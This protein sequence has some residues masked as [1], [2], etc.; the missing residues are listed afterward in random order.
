M[1]TLQIDFC[2][3]K[4]LWRCGYFITAFDTASSKRNRKMISFIF[5]LLHGCSSLQM[6]ATSNWLGIDFTS[7]WYLWIPFAVI[8]IL[9]IVTWSDSYFCVQNM[10]FKNNLDCEV[11]SPLWNGTHGA[12]NLSSSMYKMWLQLTLKFNVNS[13]EPLN[14][15]QLWITLHNTAL[16]TWWLAE[17]N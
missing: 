17:G 13:D 9:K 1:N 2:C 16:S 3:I 4:T 15:I 6:F 14:S 5:C 12:L 10:F 11:I 7:S 8:S